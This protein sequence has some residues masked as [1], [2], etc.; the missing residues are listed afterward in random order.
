MGEHNDVKVDVRLSR[1]EIRELDAWISAQKVP[2]LGRA[3]ALKRLMKLGLDAS[4]QWKN[5]Q[6]GFTPDEGLRPQQLTCENDG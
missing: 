6:A 3:E 2:G 5:S 1:E 4:W